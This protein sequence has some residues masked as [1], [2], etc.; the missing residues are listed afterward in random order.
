MNFQGG[1]VRETHF[2]EGFY[3]DKDGVA[4]DRFY[5]VNGAVVKFKKLN[6][7]T[8]IFETPVDPGELSFLGFDPKKVVSAVHTT[9][10]VTTYEG[11]KDTDHITRLTTVQW[12]EDSGTLQSI[13]FVSMKGYHTRIQ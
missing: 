6:Q 8:W 1:G 11:E 12:K 3:K 10:K 7:N 2:L 4:G 5:E 9:T 13:Q